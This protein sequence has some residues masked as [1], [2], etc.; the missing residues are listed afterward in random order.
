MA[1][2]K[3]TITVDRGK[4]EK[5]RGLTGAASNSQTIELALDELVRAERVRRDITACELKPP[6]AE[7]LARARPRIN[8]PDLTDET[9]WEAL[10]SHG[11]G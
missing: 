4:L 6:V 10:Y 1:R 7:Q 8:R 2:H 3:V 11:D 5:A 9:D